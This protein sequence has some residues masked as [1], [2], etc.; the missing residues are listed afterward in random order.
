[1]RAA[2]GEG[3]ITPSLFLRK[4]RLRLCNLLYVLRGRRHGGH[5]LKP[6]VS[7]V[8]VHLGYMVSRTARPFNQNRI[9]TP[10]PSRGLCSAS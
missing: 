5:Q 8:R 1:M 9:V 2:L 6:Q 4:Q 3:I 7:P 10:W